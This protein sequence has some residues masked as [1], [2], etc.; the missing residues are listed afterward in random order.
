MPRNLHRDA[1]VQGAVHTQ[2]SFHTRA[3]GVKGPLRVYVDGMVSADCN[4]L[5]RVQGDA[6][7]LC[8]RKAVRSV[9]QAKLAVEVPAGG[10]EGSI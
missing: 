1:R 4:G 9:A 6:T 10:I 7:H 2:A 3:E 5:D 8:E